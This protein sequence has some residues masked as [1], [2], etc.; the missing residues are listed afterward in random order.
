[1]NSKIVLVAATTIILMGIASAY[2]IFG[3]EDVS[4][5]NTFDFS[6]IEISPI[7]LKE[8]GE[9]EIITSP[10][11][12]LFDVY[13]YESDLKV[14]SM[15]NYV[16]SYMHFKLKKGNEDIYREIRVTPDSQEAVV[17]APIFT[18]TAYT[19]PGFYDYFK[20]ECD[21]SCIQSVP[22]KYDL[23][24]TLGTS[25]NAIRILKLLG[26]PVV[27]DIEIDKQPD[28][29]N[30]FDKVILLHN[31]YI[32]RTEFDAIIDHPKVIYLYPNALYAEISVDYDNQTITLLRGHNFPEQYIRNGFD[33]K[34]DNSE[35]EYDDCRNNWEFSEIDNGIMLSCYP[36]NFIYKEYDLLKFIK[37]Y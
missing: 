29:L 36:E 8:G 10:E 28:L 16:A 21:T 18:I 1:M 23:P 34:F 11:S 5:E 33:W 19:E 37:D 4:L 35:L 2:F 12:D 26:Y 20:G 6:T 7:K 31:E 22:I 32:T 30:Q 25:E 14:D 9:G 3:P 17:I 27:T 15:G 13:A 24:P